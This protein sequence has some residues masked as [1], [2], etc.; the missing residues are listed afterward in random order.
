MV[1]RF[2]DEENLR[3]EELLQRLDRHIVGMNNKNSKMVS[4]YLQSSQ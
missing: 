1:I 3:S 2:L 4:K